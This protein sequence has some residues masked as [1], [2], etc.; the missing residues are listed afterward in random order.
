MPGQ[1]R[2]HESYAAALAAVRTHIATRV[3]TVVDGV[4]PVLEAATRVRHLLEATG[5]RLPATTAD[6]RAQLG[7]L[8]RPG[9]VADAGEDRLR[10]LTRYLRAMEVRLERAAR[11]PRE[12][13]LQATIDSVETAYA[14]LLDTLP[15]PRRRSQ[16][17]LDL[18]WL[19]E[20][21]RVSLF[22]Q[23]L[24]TAEKVS[25]KRVLAAIAAQRP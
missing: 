6:V 21:L 23:G 7:S 24:G 15:E 20:E 14:D 25:D 18:A 9:F 17:V 11:N 8:V 3:L 22:A 16:A 10:H 4:I 2:T 5:S 13:Q 1:V 12:A 19:I